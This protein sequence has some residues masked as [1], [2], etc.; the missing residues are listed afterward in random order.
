[1][2]E[3]ND[4]IKIMTLVPRDFSTNGGPV[5]RILIVDDVD[6]N[7]IILARRFARQN[8]ET[9]EACD[10]R[11][12]FEK[13][14]EGKFDVV[15][16]DIMMPDISGL[17][18]LRIIRK[19]HDATAL[20]VIMVTAKVQSEDIVEAL[21]I[22]ANDYI[23][24][25]VDFAV[26][27]A[28]VSTQ[29]AAKRAAERVEM[30]NEQ[31][32]RVNEELEVR[33][34]ERTSM[35]TTLNSQ[36]QAEIAEREKSEAKTRYMALH[37]ML[38]G[39]PNRLE[40]RHRLQDALINNEAEGGKGAV[41]FIDL[42][43]FK[44]VNDQHGHAAGDAVLTIVAQRLK[45]GL[46]PHDSVARLGGDEFAILRT[47]L[48]TP[49]ELEALGNDLIRS[50]CMPCA[51][52]GREAI[53]GASIGVTMLNDIDF[54]PSSILRRA[55]VA[56]YEAKSSGRGTVCFYDRSMDKEAEARRTLE[57]DLRHAVTT[58]G[59]DLNYQPLVNLETQL[60]VGFE[61]LI[62]W[63]HPT[64]G[65]V[66]PTDFVP[67]AEEIGLI[68]RIGDWVIRAACAEAA[69][70]SEPLKV[71][72]NVSPL[73][74]SKG[75]LVMTVMSALAQSRL[76][77]HRLELEIT[78]SVLVDRTNRNKQILEQLREL[79]VRLSIDDFGTGY[80]S[81]S[82]LRNFRFDKIKLDRSFVRD[83]TSD[84]N[85]QAIVRAIGDIASKFGVL[86]TA[87]GVETAEQRNYLTLENYTEGQ[88]YLFGKPMAA[89]EVRKLVAAMSEPLRATG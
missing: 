13:L 81:L 68:N 89:E 14:A 83:V 65:Q 50:I 62:R 5:G 31:L 78:E 44:A 23:T 8:F 73:Q 17:D 10:A 47:C 48:T 27:L 66:S 64:R 45:K 4:R 75:N 41:M 87:E 74:F 77:P 80:S 6:D 34:A 82:Y 70:W 2:I 11:E 52:D 32:L 55:D 29:V 69:T 72:V 84:A 67:L 12:A 49:Q 86:T 30:M 79:G 37:D 40:F 7:R 20:P 24:K 26:A 59:F 39:L 57:T 46:G 3:I 1:V 51:V 15:L 25:P 42:D 63:N 36:L 71:A 18:A 58:G 54:D 28:R 21:T 60:V 88:G 56:M 76:A 33:V 16:L 22:G 85:C 9:V 61:A 35:L 38:T 43:G 53:V 19:T